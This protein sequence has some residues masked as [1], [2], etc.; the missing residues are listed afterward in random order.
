MRTSSRIALNFAL[1]TAIS[2]LV[3]LLF[4]NI[5]FFAARYRI[6]HNYLTSMALQQNRIQA[7]EAALQ[8]KNRRFLLPLQLRQELPPPTADDGMSDDKTLHYSRKLIGIIQANDHRRYMV[9]N[10]PN[11]QSKMLLDITDNFERQRDLAAVSLVVLLIIATTSYRISKRLVARGLA[12]LCTL[13]A[14]VKDANIENL[15]TKLEMAHLPIDDE[16]NIVARAIDDM[17]VKLHKQ[18]SSIKDFVSHVS[19]EFKTP[20]MVMRSDIDLA[21]KTKEYD[22]LIEKNKQTVEHMQTLLDG[23]LLITTAE[24]GKLKMNEIN[25]STLI[26]RVVEMMQKKYADKDVI[27]QKYIAPHVFVTAHQGAAES[28]ISNVL[29]NAYKYTPEWGSITLTLNEKECVIADTW[30][31]ISKEHKEKIRQPFWQADKNRQDGV[32][33]GLAIVHKLSAILWWTVRIEDNVL[34]DHKDVGTK[35]TFIFPQE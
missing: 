31:W 15:N 18:I 30:I 1:F 29:D 3:I 8:K 27:V 7:I 13:A 33:L 34:P 20:L 26:E 11:D 22:E 32:G 6:D 2:T 16:I 19:H 28:A 23:L 25:M 14:G 35:V 12:D 9:Y 4:I 10:D 5:G 17:K 21:Q 24:T